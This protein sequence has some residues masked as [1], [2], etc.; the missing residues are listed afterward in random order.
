MRAI[1]FLFIVLLTASTCALAVLEEP[2]KALWR[3]AVTQGG[4]HILTIYEQTD[5]GLICKQARGSETRTLLEARAAEH[6]VHPAQIAEEL[7]VYLW[8]DWSVFYVSGYDMST[9]IATPQSAADFGAFLDAFYLEHHAC[10]LPAMRILVAGYEGHYSQDDNGD[11]HYN[12]K[13]V[14]EPYPLYALDP[15][16]FPGT[17]IFEPLGIVYMSRYADLLSVAWIRRQVVKHFAGIIET[18]SAA[19]NPLKVAR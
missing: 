9:F 8:D 17:G 11:F 5:E 6:N 19:G 2:S 13:I 7:S 3:Y 4:R 15:K 1:T 10:L 12:R 16:H 14:A 18:R